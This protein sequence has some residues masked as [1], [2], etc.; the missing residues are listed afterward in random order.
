MASK[1]PAKTTARRMRDYAAAVLTVLIKDVATAANATYLKANAAF[2][3][4]RR[5]PASVTRP[6]LKLFDYWMIIIRIVAT[7]IITAGITL[8]ATRTYISIGLSRVFGEEVDADL[9]LA[10]LGFFNKSLD[11]I[12]VSSLEYMASFLLTVWMARAPTVVGGRHGATYNDFGLKDELTKPWMTVASFITRGRRS[13]WKWSW[14]SVFRLILCLCVSISVMLQGLA[15]NTVAIPKKR[16]YPNLQAKWGTT[17]GDRKIMHIEYPKVLLQGVDWGNMVG[18]GQSNIGGEGYPLWDWALGMSASLTF[19]GL[20]HMVST[21]R[22]SQKGWRHIYDYRLDGDPWKR[23][24]A[25]NT[26]FGRSNGVVETVSADD[27]QIT[28]IYDWL[29]KTRHQPTS[30]SIGWTGNLTLM[31]PVLNT[32]CTPIVSSSSEGSIDVQPP[33][34]NDA[35]GA[36][37]SI[38]LGPVS[39]LGFTGAVCSSTFRHGKYAVSVWIVE[40]ESPDLSFNGYGAEWH[41]NIVYEPT[42]TSDLD[43][44]RGVGGQ[45]HDVMPR[46]EPLVPSTGLLPQ[47]LLMSRNLQTADPVVNSDAMGLSIIVGVLLQNILSTSNKYWSPLPSS[48]PA[49]PEERT[50]S[51]PIQWQLYGSSPRLKWEWAAVAI[52]VIVLLT[53][54]FGMYQTLRYW[55]APGPWVELDGM[56]MIA[57]QTPQLESIEDEKKAQKRMYSVEKDGSGVLILRSEAG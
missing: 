8:G 31:L 27:G 46:L 17:P 51:Y 21:V 7:G 45:A 54:C 30:S 41:Q 36:V 10:F 4:A 32:V 37:I 20:T 55:M 38:D 25:L 18:V 3:E 26:D 47:F 53:F 33:A 13:S 50:S 23:W 15:I 56:M 2:L 14:R 22:E 49:R 57:Q 9:K 39:S 1:A 34:E 28:N 19:V 44:A 6:Q 24:T 12:L 43:V 35:S 16:W 52:L 5:R 42:I 11:V 48:L 29:K 40:S